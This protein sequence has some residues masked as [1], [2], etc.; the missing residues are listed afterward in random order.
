[1]DAN[2]LAS[3]E[4]DY[5]PIPEPMPDVNVDVSTEAPRTVV[6][7]NI[8]DFKSLANLEGYNF[9]DRY[10]ADNKCNVISVRKIQGQTIHG[11]LLNPYINR[12]SYVEYVLLD[13]DKKLK[14][15]NGH[16]IVAGLFLPKPKDKNYV[17]HKDGNRQNNTVGNLEW[18]S[19]S[20]NIYHSWNSIR[21]DDTKFKYTRRIPGGKIMRTYS[22]ED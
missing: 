14:H 20:E 9:D 12:D 21:K 4:H 18:V 10:Y 13:K 8:R 15:L 19:H 16:R 22:N 7:V 6:T 17:N 2:I 3:L 1:M 11:I 5:I